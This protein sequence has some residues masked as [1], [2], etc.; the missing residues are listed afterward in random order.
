MYN[1]STNLLTLYHELCSLISYATP[2]LFCCTEI[3]NN[4]TIECLCLETIGLILAPWKFD[5]YLSWELRFSG[6]YLF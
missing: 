4:N 2:F 3:V 5:A 6:K 1:F